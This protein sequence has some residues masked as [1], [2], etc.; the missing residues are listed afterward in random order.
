MSKYFITNEEQQLAAPLASSS[1][2]FDFSSLPPPFVYSGSLATAPF[3]HADRPLRRA[4]APPLHSSELWLVV[5]LLFPIFLSC[6]SIYM[7][8][9][10]KFMLW[11]DVTIM[12]IYMHWKLYAV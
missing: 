11:D 6:L 12:H 5:R 8:W 7:H 9:G 3:V 10:F 4:T 1:P 2:L